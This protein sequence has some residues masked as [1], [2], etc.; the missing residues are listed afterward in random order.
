MQMKWLGP[1][2]MEF[3]GLNGAARRKLVH[4]SEWGVLSVT[5]GANSWGE[6][7]VIQVKD[8]AGDPKFIIIPTGVHGRHLKSFS[9]WLGQSCGELEAGG[10]N[11]DKTRVEAV[12]VENSKGDRSGGDVVDRTSVVDRCAVLVMGDGAPA[13][14]CSDV[15][16]DKKEVH[17]PASS[18]L[19][20]STECAEEYSG[21]AADVADLG[22]SNLTNLKAP[23]L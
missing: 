14:V 13:A 22:S 9:L 21:K 2:L 4:R 7:V 6:F 8:K 12:R 3:Q 19:V 10:K 11:K 18:D 17:A 1:A 5:E 15:L 16:L 20:G 23:G